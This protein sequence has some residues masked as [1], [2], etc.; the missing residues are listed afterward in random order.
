MTNCLETSNSLTHHPRTF[1]SVIGGNTDLFYNT[2]KDVQLQ[3]SSTP[4]LNPLY[5]RKLVS[6]SLSS[7]FKSIIPI[8]FIDSF[9]ST[10]LYLNYFQQDFFFAKWND[11]KNPLSSK[12]MMKNHT[13]ILKIIIIR[14]YY[15]G[16][17][18]FLLIIHFPKEWFLMLM[19]LHSFKIMFNSLRYGPIINKSSECTIFCNRNAVSVNLWWK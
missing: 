17:C 12:I 7:T 1:I 13:E 15:F 16:I 11:F 2:L 5:R 18:P 14:F 10:S 8:F 19:L 4:T 9:F 6:F 3:L